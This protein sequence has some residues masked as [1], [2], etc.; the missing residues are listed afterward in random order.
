MNQ[1]IINADDFGLTAGVNRAILEL[2]EAS[3]LTSTT[4]MAS[5]LAFTDAISTAKTHPSL[6]IGCHVVLVDG[7]PVLPPEQIPSLLKPGT[8]EFRRTLGEFLKDL[9]LGKIQEK[10]VEAEA[11]AQISKLKTNGIAVTHVDTHKHSHMFPGVLRPVVRAALANG[12]K[13][14]RNPFEPTW[15][16][17]ATPGAPLVRRMQVHVLRGAFESYFKKCVL[18]AGLFTTKGA[19]GV[20]STGTLDTATV[21]SLLQHL[22]DGTW[23]LVCHPGYQDEDLQGIRTRLRKSRE[24]EKLALLEAVQ[25]AAASTRL[26]H[27]GELSR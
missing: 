2:H 17:S 18:H 5:S 20:L 12:V 13:A 27:F 16:L 14:I 25:D 8:G 26:I 11:S 1:L 4:L 3:S 7:T 6:G 10:D 23:E 15:S 22:P 21:R 24:V 19:I 9:Y